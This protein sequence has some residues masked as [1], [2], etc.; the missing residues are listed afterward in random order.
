MEKS[1]RAQ[2]GACDLLA[3][4]YLIYHFVLQ[5][6]HLSLAGGMDGW[7]DG[8]MDIRKKMVFVCVCRVWRK[9]RDLDG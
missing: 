7:M 2:I 6:L 9:T 3:R 1:V 8:S 4:N 5:A